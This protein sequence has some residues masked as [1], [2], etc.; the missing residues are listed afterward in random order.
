[1][2]FELGCW[3][4]LGENIGG[5]PGSRAILNRK[6]PWSIAIAYEV[7]SDVN[8]LGACVILIIL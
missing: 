2:L 3:Q 6:C 5:V 8:M 7:V 1:M 4:S